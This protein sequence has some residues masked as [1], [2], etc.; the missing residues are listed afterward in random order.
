MGDLRVLQQ[1][2]LHSVRGAFGHS[3]EFA[4][5]FHAPGVRAAG[6]PR[7]DADLVSSISSA[8]EPEVALWF[9]EI[10]PNFPGRVAV[11]VEIAHAGN[12]PGCQGQGRIGGGSQKVLTGGRPASD[13]EHQIGA[14]FTHATDDQ[15]SGGH[16][17][18]GTVN[19]QPIGPHQ[20]GGKAW[21]SE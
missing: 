16:D 9:G 11:P 13:T 8:F 15:R 10:D 1:G 18:H 12:W 4:G 17:R 21:K 3:T 14:G 6:E 19:Q 5:E 2:K 20:S 7:R